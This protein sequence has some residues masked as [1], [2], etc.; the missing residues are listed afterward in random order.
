MGPLPVTD[1]TVMTLSPFRWTLKMD[2]KLCLLTQGE[3]RQALY[4]ELSMEPCGSVEGTL[5]MSG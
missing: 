4:Q 1:S 2:V 5:E 3:E